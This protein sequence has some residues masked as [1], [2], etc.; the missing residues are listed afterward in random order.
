MAAAA[1]ALLEQKKKTPTLYFLFGI[2]LICF[3]QAARLELL[4][5]DF[6]SMQ[7]AHCEELEGRV[8]TKPL[9]DLF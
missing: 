6:L 1:R 7:S 4:Y 5:V 8:L 9:I 3:A 2:E